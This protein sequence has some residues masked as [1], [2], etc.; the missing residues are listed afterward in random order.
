MADVF[1][2]IFAALALLLIPA[3]IV[4]IVFLIGLFIFFYNALITAR[5]R[6][7]NAWSQIDVQLK[8]RNDLVPNLVETVKGYAKQERTVFENVTKARAS[9]VNAGS[10]AEK[11]KASDF[12]SGALKS[13]FAVAEAYPQLRSSENFKALQD[14][15]S[16]IESKIAF[17][18]QFYNDSVLDL[19]LKVQTFPS[20]IVA[21]FMGYKLKDYFGVPEGDR[22]APKVK[23]E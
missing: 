19:N 11:A 10:V 16:G 7:E 23:F 3:V 13:V 17:A 2:W 8:R 4:I 6:A 21:N 1:P 18:R 12:L 5:N 9:M 20:S 22:A 15:L 14:E